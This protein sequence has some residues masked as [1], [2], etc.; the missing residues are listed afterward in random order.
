M[1]VPTLLLKVVRVSQLTPDVASF[2][3]EHPEG[4]PL[5][6]F[7]AGAHIDVHLPDGMIRQYS[8]CNHT[9]DSDHYLIAVK[10]EPSSRG[11]S[12]AMHELRAGS[13]LSIGSPRNSF[14]ISEEAHFHLL[15]AGGIGITP[16]LSMARHLQRDRKPFRIEYFSRS[17]DGTPFYDVISQEMGARAGFNIGL[18]PD[19]VRKKL[20]GVLGDRA[21]G[22]HVYICGPVAFMDMASEIASQSWPAECV[23]LEHFSPQPNIGQSESQPFKVTLA[24]SNRQFEIPA[25]KSILDVLRENRIPCDC[26]CREGICGS[27]MVAVLEGEVDHRD[28]YLSAEEKERGD[29]MMICVSRAK[30]GDLMIDM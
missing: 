15:L 21:A 13:L 1:A 9:S 8:L 25:D 22:A 20:F 3:L 27:C 19:G 30:N 2:R 16:L 10:W 23:H 4:Q 17:V 12:K 14:P 28:S 7:A 11:G 6:A 5:P 29:V 24:Q 26:S 18:E